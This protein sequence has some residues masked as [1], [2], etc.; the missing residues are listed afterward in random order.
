MPF[1]PRTIARCPTTRRL[2]RCGLCLVVGCPFFSRL[3]TVVL[4]VTPA[5]DPDRMTD[6]VISGVIWF[7]FWIIFFLVFMCRVKFCKSCQK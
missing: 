4:F 7:A 6:G 5:W 3:T 1:T 2:R